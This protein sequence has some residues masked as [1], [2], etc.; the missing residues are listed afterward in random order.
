VLDQFS[1]V[2]KDPLLMLVNLVVS[3]KSPYISTNDISGSQHVQVV[4]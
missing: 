4:C 1:L 2:H 3:K